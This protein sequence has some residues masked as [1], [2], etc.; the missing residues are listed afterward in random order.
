MSLNV[1]SHQG[2]GFA[3]AIDHAK[4]LLD[5][6]RPAQTSVETPLTTLNQALASNSAP[7]DSDTLRQQGA[8]AYEQTMT[9]LALRA[10]S[11]DGRWR[12]FTGA[13]YEGRVIGSFDRGWFALWEPRAMQGVL[14]PG[15]GSELND[16]RRLAEDIRHEV[17]TVG[18]AA[19]RADVNPGTRRD[20][21]RKYRLDYSGWGR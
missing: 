15:C 12:S 5:G 20:A 19:R 1:P 11:L 7:S 16:I 6:K 8:A 17:V 3:I 10:D 4:S 14:S 18:E 13:C 9:Q 21:L 2:L